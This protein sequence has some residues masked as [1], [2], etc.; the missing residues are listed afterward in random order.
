MDKLQELVLNKFNE[1]QTI[2]VSRDLLLV[3][4]RCE[5]IKDKLTMTNL[6]KEVAKKNLKNKK[7]LKEWSAVYW[8]AMLVE[9]PYDFDSYLLYLEKNRP[10]EKAFYIPRRKTLKPIVDALN[11][12]VY[13][14]LDELFVSQP[15]RTGKSTL[16]IMYMTWLIGRDSEKS[17]LYVSFTDKITSSF[18]GAVLE[19]I[20]DKDTYC[21]NDIFP[22][23]KIVQT[24]A[25]DETLDMDR[26]KH[27]KSLT[28]RSIDGTLNG[29]CD[30]NG[31]LI[32]DDLV[33]GIEEALSK[34]RMATL[35]SKVSNDMLSRVKSGGK[36]IW[37][38]TRW[39][40]TDPIGMRK[41]ILENNPKFSDIRYKI[42][43]L[44]AINEFGESNFDY[45]YGVGF[46][47]A[48]YLRIRDMFEKNNDLASWNAQYMGEPIEREGSLITPQDLEYYNGILP[49]E[50]CDRTFMY[51]DP[52]FGGKDFT[53]SPIIKQFGD[54]G[55]VVDVVYTNLGKT[56]SQP[57]IVSKVL[58]WGVQAIEFEANNGGTLYK[59]DIERLLKEKNYKCNI[60][61]KYTTRYQ[62][63]IR[64]QSKDIRIHDKAPDIMNDFIF[65]EDIKRDKEYSEFMS[66]VFSFVV[67]GKNKHD[68]AIDSLCGADDMMTVIVP[69][70]E[71]IKRRI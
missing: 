60:T 23:S 34:D 27:Y 26:K 21:F 61:T 35:W 36:L 32:A 47:T 58:K 20:E 63:S 69:K 30:V 45:K 5:N 39:S 67:L 48:T 40:Q 65:L 71:L 44:P 38:G 3:A 28:C 59:D 70:I 43:N 52:S 41:N 6:V 1:T 16:L 56:I 62:Q 29:A 57:E 31:V 37:N 9:A 51:V 19:I 2:N 50:E 15:P 11:M 64:G 13:D 42:V 8:D 46:D 54:K 53:A 18:Y 49:D 4:K 66:N 25:K 22:N 10:N 17:N 7:D 12:F 14:E 24:N 55:Y 33:S 68:D